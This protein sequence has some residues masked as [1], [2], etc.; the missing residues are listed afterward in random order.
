MI[1]TV[2]RTGLTRRL[3]ILTS[4]R[5]R[6]ARLTGMET[7]IA[8]DE[9]DHAPLPAPIIIRRMPLPK[10]APT[11]GFLLPDQPHDSTSPVPR[12]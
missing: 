10:P 12:E 7:I 6:R 4:Q 9:D 5:A 2:M 8:G 11:P 3:E 1:R